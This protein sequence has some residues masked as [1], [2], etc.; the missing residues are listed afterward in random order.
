MSTEIK[1]TVQ[2]NQFTSGNINRATH[3]QYSASLL[4]SSPNENITKL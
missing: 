3:R 2:I 4:R 1:K